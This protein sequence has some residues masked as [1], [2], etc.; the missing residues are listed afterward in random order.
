MIELNHVT[1]RY[2][3]D[4]ED[5]IH[6]VSLQFH[7]S[8]ITALMGAN[9]S[10]KTTLIRCMNGLLKCTSGDVLVDGLS[11]H[12]AEHLIEIRRKVGMVFQNPDNQIVTTTVEREI[13]FGLENLGIEPE[14]MRRKVAEALRQ[15]HLEPMQD[16]APHLLSGGERQRLALAAVCVMSPDYLILDEPTALLDPRGRAEFLAYISQVR[17]SGTGVVFVT[18][19][20]EEACGCDRLIILDSGRIA[21]DGPP[22]GIF[23]EVEQVHRLGV[24]V[25]VAVELSV[26]FGSGSDAD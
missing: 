2:R 9:G 26:L 23:R 24:Q 22:A 6:D 4:R 20:A 18:Q 17:K 12:D 5:V 14:L 15:F 3:D 16:T 13:A 25:P 8:Q 21:M 10:G 19:S 11:V 1:Y 7:R